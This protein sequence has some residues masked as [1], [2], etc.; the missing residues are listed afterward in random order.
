MKSER[1][2]FVSHRKTRCGIHEFGARTAEAL[3]QSRRHEYTYVECAN[4]SEFHEAVAKNDP[5]AI[6]YNHHPS[7][8]PWL[9]AAAIRQQKSIHIG[10]VHEITQ[11]LADRLDNRLFDFHIAPDPTLYLRNPI[12]FKTGRLVP[13]HDCE[14]TTKI[15]VPVIG[16]FGFA[17][18]GKGFARLVGM[19][20][21]QFE[22]A[23]IRLRIPYASFGDEDGDRARS[24]AEQCRVILGSRSNIDLEI[25]HDY[26][27]TDALLAF[28]AENTLNVFLYEQQNGR[29]I[30]SVT[31]YALAVRRPVAISSS[32]MFRHLWSVRPSVNADYESLPKIIER[33]FRPLEPLV[34]EW[35]AENLVWEYDRIVDSVL[36]RKQPGR[37]RPIRAAVY[38]VASSPVLAPLRRR[39]GAMAFAAEANASSRSVSA[40]V[41]TV[42]HVRRSIAW[43]VRRMR[44]LPSAIGDAPL[45]VQRDWVPS[46]DAPVLQPAPAAD[47]VPYS[48]FADHDG[49][50]NRILDNSARELY[51]P[52]I[53]YLFRAAPELMTR[54]IREANVQQGFVLD[55]VSRLIKGIEHPAILS[56]GSYED[57]ATVAIMRSGH[58]VEEIDPVINYDLAS[59]M[60]RPSCKRSHF[61]V[62]FAT[63][64]IEHITDDEQFLRAIQELLA[65]GGFG[66]LTCD[67]NNQY[68]V[69]DPIPPEDRRFYT[70]RDFRE[71]VLPLLDQCELVGAPNW[72][73]GV[74]DFSYGEHRYTFASLVFRRASYAY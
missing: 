58:S 28:L 2:L 15:D 35:T 72:D 54:K 49:R 1:I 21:E 61:D 10:I 47:I 6:I 65:P 16:S 56:I 31:D 51:A 32:M 22:R 41:G 42:S 24:A 40:T 17:T 53:D 4:G 70:A 7:T 66:V 64:V 74:P 52:A 43:A 9:N 60:S 62:V 45:E 20:A 68:R 27:P 11:S 71:R 14:V 50:F 5:A 25:L 12:V 26:V 46:N 44:T 63:S 37:R 38:A 36:A 34:H 13:R 18:Q 19:V 33:G 29:G 73:H 3:R 55:T 48:P 8:L 30:A 59:Y 23:R 57:T 69:G 67:F 39:L